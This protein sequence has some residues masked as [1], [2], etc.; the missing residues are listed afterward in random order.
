[1]QGHRGAVILRLGPNRSTEVPEGYSLALEG[2]DVADYTIFYKEGAQGIGELVGDGLQVTG[3]KFVEDGKLF[4]RVNDEVY[5]VLGN[6]I[7]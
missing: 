3:E 4:I 5:D 7:R 1:M 6:K 2:G